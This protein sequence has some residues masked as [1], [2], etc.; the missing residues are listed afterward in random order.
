MSGTL[1][2]ASEGPRPLCPRA[3]RSQARYVR[4]FHVDFGMRVQQ[5]VDSPRVR[6]PRAMQERL[7]ELGHVVVQQGET[8][9]PTNFA[10]FSAVAR[11]PATGELRPARVRHGTRRPPGS[12]TCGGRRTWTVAKRWS[13]L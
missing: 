4:R 9:A 12:D 11:A 8:P 7:R 6:I 3:C 10:R 1:R 13:R 2:A 5:A